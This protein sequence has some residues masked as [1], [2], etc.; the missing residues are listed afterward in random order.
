MLPSLTRRM[1]TPGSQHSFGKRPSAMALKRL[2][3]SGPW[4]KVQRKEWGQK[5]TPVAARL[6]LQCKQA[7]DL[8]RG[9]L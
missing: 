7:L 4:A 1:Y 5:G 6:F 3:S 8:K 9:L 2:S